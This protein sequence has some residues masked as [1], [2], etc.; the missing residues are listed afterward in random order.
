[1]I[2]RADGLQARPT[3]AALHGRTIRGHEN[4]LNYTK[5][6]P[7]GCYTPS[8]GITGRQGATHNIADGAQSESNANHDCPQNAHL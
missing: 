4:T 1:M 6:G 3:I 5:E 8:G 7:M 2:P